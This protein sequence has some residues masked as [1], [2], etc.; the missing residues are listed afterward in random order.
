MIPALIYQT[1]LVV[2]GWSV[3][4]FR[5]R[6]NNDRNNNIYHIIIIIIIIIMC[7][8]SISEK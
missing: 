1:E 3:M 7:R 8:I 5:G 4:I 2:S 6:F